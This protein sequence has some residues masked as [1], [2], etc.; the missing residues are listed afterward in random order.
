MLLPVLSGKAQ[1]VTASAT[2]AVALLPLLAALFLLTVI[3]LGIYGP[4]YL[5]RI[6]RYLVGELSYKEQSLQ[7]TGRG[8]R[9]LLIIASTIV[10]PIIPLMLA[11]LIFWSFITAYL[12][13]I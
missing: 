10:I 7:F 5:T 11:Q 3:T 2:Q 12:Y 13:L 1:A 4:W 6:T 9:L 8:G